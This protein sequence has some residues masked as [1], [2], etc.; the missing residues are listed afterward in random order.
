MD[1][2]SRSVHAWLTVI[3]LTCCRSSEASNCQGRMAV[4]VSVYT[5]LQRVH[6]SYEEH[7]WKL[8][9]K[10]LCLHGGGS[11]SCWAW[12]RNISLPRPVVTATVIEVWKHRRTSGS[13]PVA[14]RVLSIFYLLSKD[15]R[16]DGAWSWRL[17]PSRDWIWH[18]FVGE[19]VPCMLFPPHVRT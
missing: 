4:L 14:F 6:Q 1:W 8:G 9:Q 10:M 5:G 18:W 13:L 17:L 3:Q 16:V 15:Q 12:L 11:V 19:V 2:P 7:V